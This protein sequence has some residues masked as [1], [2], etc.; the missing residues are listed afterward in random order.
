MNP[1]LNV[2]DFNGDDDDLSNIIQG[3]HRYDYTFF[4]LSYIG[5]SNLDT[6]DPTSLA[7]AEWHYNNTF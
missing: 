3:K 6:H 2:Y 7:T 5:D 1:K 4:F